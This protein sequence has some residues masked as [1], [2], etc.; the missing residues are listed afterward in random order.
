MSTTIIDFWKANPSYWITIEAKKQQEADEKICSEF[1]AL[2]PYKQNLIGQVI[3][4]D[5]FSRHFQRAGKITEE[6]VLVN[7]E[8]AVCLIQSNLSYLLKMDETELV[9]ALMPFK[10]LGL[11]KFIF[12]YLHTTW[13]PNNETTLLDNPL[14]HKFYMDTYKK[15]FTF[16]SVKENI[17]LVHPSSFTDSYNPQN[18]C[19]FYPDEYK[20]EGW[21]I[22]HTSP[23][24]EKLLKSLDSIKEE[25]KIVVSLSGGVDSMVMLALLSSSNAKVKVKKTPIAVH[26]VYGNRK[27]SEDECQFLSEYCHKLNV[28]LLVYRIQWLKRGEV[29][30]TFY[31][32]MTR[33]IRFFVYRA[34]EYPVCLGHIQDDVVEN[35]WTNIANCKHL[36]NLKKIVKEEVQQGVCILRPFLEAEKKD[37]YQVSKELGIPY[38]KNTTPSWSNRGKFRE[39]FHQSTLTQFGEKVDTK[40][41]QFAEAIEKQNQML[42]TL[43]YKP[44]FDSF[45]ENY[46]TITPAVQADLDSSGWLFIFETI[47]H[48]HLGIS[49]PSLKS[50]G[51]FCSRLKTLKEDQLY[52]DMTK[53]FSVKV[54]K[55]G[56][57]VIIEIVKHHL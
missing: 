9:F 41:I 53:Q 22:N 39:E 1:L 57:E 14:L 52:I 35:I 43:L 36:D 23:T 19:S 26:I 45:K 50:V 56:K 12:Q 44:I 42:L 18:I 34:I 8:E 21:N 31:E 51:N 6:D 28:P 11:Y 49:K 24:I 2:N 13:L 17:H 27:E 25:E 55:Q 4:L 40:I 48:K 29:D 38:L 7:R 15:A 5:Q 33:D 46:I 32:S 16:D 47:S 30:R 3:F 20:E 10:H 37:I 54:M